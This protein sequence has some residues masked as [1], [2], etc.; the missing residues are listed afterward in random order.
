MKNLS[1]PNLNSETPSFADL[2]LQKDINHLLNERYQ[3][4]LKKNEAISII[5]KFGDDASYL[6]AQ[7]GDDDRAHVFEFF[8]RDCVESD[9]DGG[10]DLLLDYLDGTLLEFFGEDRNA[11]FPLDFTPRDFA[12]QQIWVRHQFHD[13]KAESLALEFLKKS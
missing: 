13:F 7:I 3:T 2:N 6:N 11:F 5:A 4:H 9:L 10:L 12:S 1:L 8:V